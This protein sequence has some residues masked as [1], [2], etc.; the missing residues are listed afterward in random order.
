MVTKGTTEVSSG[1]YISVAAKMSGLHV[2]TLRYYEKAGIVEPSRSEGNIRLYSNEDIERIKRAKTLINNLGVNLAGVD[3]IMRMA[4][5]MS[6]M[7]ALIRDLET[8][9]TKTAVK[10]KSYTGGARKTSAL[11]KKA[12]SD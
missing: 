6:Q 5:R 11:R 7:E 10:T 2:Q 4:E 8:K 12:V 9:P 3:V 1:Y